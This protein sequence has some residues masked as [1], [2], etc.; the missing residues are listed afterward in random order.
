MILK[1]LK[2]VLIVY[3]AQQMVVSIADP[4][5]QGFLLNIINI[6]FA[7]NVFKVIRHKIFTIIIRGLM[8]LAVIY[9]VFMYIGV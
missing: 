4:S 3:I 5:I 9:V 7:L 2:L 8:L 6:L 1:I